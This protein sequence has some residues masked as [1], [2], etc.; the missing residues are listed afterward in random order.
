M[1]DEPLQF[2]NVLNLLAISLLAQVLENFLRRGGAQVGADESGFQVVQGRAINFLAEGN[3]FLNALAEVLAGSRDRFL[4]AL[5]EAGLLFGTAKKSLNHEN[6]GVLSPEVNY[7]GGRE[8][9]WED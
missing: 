8:M 1:L 7:S 9:E 3:G 4:H 6:W 5:Q 2:G